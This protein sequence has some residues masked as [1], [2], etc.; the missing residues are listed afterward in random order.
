[1]QALIASGR[2]R[3]AIYYED[4]SH[5]EKIHCYFNVKMLFQLRKSIVYMYTNYLIPLTITRA[6]DIESLHCYFDMLEDTLIKED[7]IFCI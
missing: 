5:T 3:A 4:Q 2:Y 7:S 6:I 1:M